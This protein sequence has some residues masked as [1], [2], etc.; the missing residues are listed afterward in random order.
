MIPHLFYYQL[1]ILRLL[2]LCAM[3]H[4]AWPDCYFPKS[5]SVEKG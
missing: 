5:S 4:Y 2:W 3:L 1:V